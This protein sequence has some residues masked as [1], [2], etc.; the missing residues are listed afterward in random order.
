MLIFFVGD[1]GTG[2]NGKSVFLET[3]CGLLGT[4]YAMAA[5]HGFLI[6]TKSDKHPT[7]VADLHGKRLVAATETEDGCRLS[8]SLVKQLTGGDRLRARRM[9]EDFWG[10]TPSHT[11]ILTTNRRPTIRGT[12]NGIWR[13]IRLVPFT[14]TIPAAE[15]DSE[16][17]KKLE[18]EWPAILRWIV[19]GCIEWQ[20]EGLQAP[21]EVLAATDNYRA[22]MDVLGEFLK[23]CCLKGAGYQVSAKNLYRT[24][25][26]WAEARGEY[27]ETQTKFGTRLAEREFSK[28]YDKGKRVIYLGLGLLGS[29]E[30]GPEGWESFSV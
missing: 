2:A 25:R 15:Q 27:V 5:P 3:T 9:R 11:V 4:D 18:S 10:F 13:R 23:E 21:N 17:K 24:Y 29:G 6:A 30:E 28:D 22:D 8:E 7:E 19:A 12:D 14:V 26:E 16:L 20:R 1:T